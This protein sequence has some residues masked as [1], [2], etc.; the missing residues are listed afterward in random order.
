MDAATPPTAAEPPAQ[1]AVGEGRVRL[2]RGGL[3]RLHQAGSAKVRFCATQ[4]GVREAVLLN[5][6]GGLTGGD[7]FA[8]SVALAQGARGRVVTQACEKVYRSTGPPANVDVALEVAA[9]ASLEWLPQETILFEGACLRRRFDVRIAPGGRLL[10]VEAVILGRAAMGETRIEA[11]LDDRW[12]VQWG[13]RLIFADNLRLDLGPA[14]TGRPAALRDACAFALVLLVAE[15]AEARL[16]AVR[17]SLGAQ[18]GAS[19]WDG[20]LV[21]RIAAP[22]GL[23]LRRAITAV[24]GVLRAGAAAPR[25]WT[26]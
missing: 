8:W 18:G 16:D 6:A 9:G 21:C 3:E 11:R 25:L 17:E 10:A 14:T 22:D 26:V 13:E 23:A 24:S 5:T 12:R 15:D 1:R 7:R 2:G 20:K 4:D 19:A